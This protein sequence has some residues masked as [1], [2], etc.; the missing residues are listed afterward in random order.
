[1][2]DLKIILST[3]LVMFFI[4]LSN[5]YAQEKND[6]S[7][8][9]MFTIEVKSINEESEFFKANIKYPFLKIKENYNDKNTIKVIN[10][11]N[12]DIE[13][14]VLNFKEEIENSLKNMKMNIQMIFQKI[15]INNM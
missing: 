8:N 1:M 15:K 7:A 3:I 6:L 9:N 12:E 14:Y 13:K 5:S 2:K 10:K 11:I 4:V